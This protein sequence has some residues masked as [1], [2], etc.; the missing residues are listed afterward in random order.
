MLK[1]IMNREKESERDLKKRYVLISMGSSTLGTVN[2]LIHSA[3]QKNSI[4]LSER[5]ILLDLTYIMG[6][7]DH[8]AINVETLED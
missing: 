7:A 2:L 3:Q 5:I 8:I 6:I 4:I 1:L